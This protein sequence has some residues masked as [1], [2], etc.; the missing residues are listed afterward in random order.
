MSFFKPNGRNCCCD[1]GVI[2]EPPCDDLV[3]R[4]VT[5]DFVIPNN[6]DCTFDPYWSSTI[7]NSTPPFYAPGTFPSAFPTPSGSDCVL[8]YEYEA[9]TSDNTSA[10]VSDDG[11]PITERYYCW[12]EYYSSTPTWVFPPGQKLS[13]IYNSS[14]FGPLMQ[15]QWNTS[16]AGTQTLTI[17]LTE[18]VAGPTTNTLYDAGNPAIPTL[19]LDTWHEFCVYFKLG[20]GANI[21]DGR[22]VAWVNGAI[23]VDSGNIIT[24]TVNANLPDGSWVGGNHTWN[25]TGPGG[26]TEVPADQTRLLDDIKVDS[27]L[28][29]DVVLP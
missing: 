4:L 18:T 29:C 26:H 5:E 21:A 7:N 24:H 2:V 19:A 17:L 10:Q 1:G 14:G 22:I 13:R 25:G 11:T 8:H 9:G 12:N 6:S 20:S 16:A 15:H 27:A 28:P 23:I 3:D